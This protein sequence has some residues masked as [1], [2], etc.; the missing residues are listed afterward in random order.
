[1]LCRVVRARDVKEQEKVLH[2]SWE[3]SVD[4]RYRSNTAEERTASWN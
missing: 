2:G 3:K 4:K 1:M